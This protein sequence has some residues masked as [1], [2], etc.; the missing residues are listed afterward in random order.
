MNKYINNQNY[1]FLILL[2]K[3][4][5]DHKN[6]DVMDYSV[7]INHIYNG[8]VQQSNGQCV[9]MTINDFKKWY[10]DN[11]KIKNLKIYREK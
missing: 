7:Y 3:K 4:Y 2:S 5:K 1:E 10:F 9:Y 8:Q 6:I 11:K